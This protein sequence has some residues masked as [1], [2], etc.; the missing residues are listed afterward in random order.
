LGQHE[1]SWNSV[2]LNLNKGPELRSTWWMR[3]RFV[4][5]TLLAFIPLIDWWAVIAVLAFPG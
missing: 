5:W 2:K 4:R 1:E 3:L